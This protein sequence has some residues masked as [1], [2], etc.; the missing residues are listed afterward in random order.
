MTHISISDLHSAESESLLVPVGTK[1]E[2]LI[3]AAISRSLDAR[4]IMGSGSPIA[5]GSIGHTTGYVGDDP[6]NLYPPNL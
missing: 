5:L 1:A 4:K 2:S 3:R 6:P